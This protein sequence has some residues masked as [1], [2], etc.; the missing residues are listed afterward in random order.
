M[1]F[2]V[3]WDAAKNEQGLVEPFRYPTYTLHGTSPRTPIAHQ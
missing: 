3:Y 1:K 2:N